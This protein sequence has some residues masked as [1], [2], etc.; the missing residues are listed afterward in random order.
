MAFDKNK[1]TEF[2]IIR[3]NFKDRE[4]RDGFREHREGFEDFRRR[5]STRTAKAL[6]AA[7]PMAT[8]A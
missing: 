7:R 6:P 4:S 5:D 8:A 2:G 1:E 3:N